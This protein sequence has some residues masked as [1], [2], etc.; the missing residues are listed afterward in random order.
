MMKQDLLFGIKITD[1]NLFSQVF[2]N[3]F[4]TKLQKFL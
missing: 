4:E 1:F 3:I 2:S